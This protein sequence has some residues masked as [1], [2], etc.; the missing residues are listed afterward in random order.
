MKVV[1]DTNILI[2]YLNGIDAARKEVERCPGAA[3]S[4]ITWM[5]VTV[6]SLVGEELAVRS[7]LRRFPCIGVDQ[8]IAE[9]AVRARRERRVKLPDAIILATARQQGAV[10][11]TRNTRDFPPTLP[12]IRIPYEL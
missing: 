9:G 1:F 5:E 6:G 4:I 2:D 7:F 8:V 11:V 12:G 3:I 10:L